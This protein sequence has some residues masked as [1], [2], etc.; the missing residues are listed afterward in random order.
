MSAHEVE[1]HEELLPEILS[2]EGDFRA[3]F[4]ASPL[5][6]CEECRRLF[7]DLDGFSMQLDDAGEAERR[8]VLEMG[9]APNQREAEAIERETGF[10]PE[11]VAA[12]LSAKFAASHETS[13]EMDSVSDPES[14]VE[15]ALGGAFSSPARYPIAMALAVVVLLGIG[16]GWALIA[17]EVEPAPWTP[18]GEE[19]RLVHPRDEVQSYAPFSWRAP[20]PDN[21]TFRV[22]VFDESTGRIGIEPLTSSGHLSRQTWT[23]SPGELEKLPGRIRWELRVYDASGALVRSLPAWAS[24]VSR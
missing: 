9:A 23:P 20:R 10:G 1:R 8:E 5:F 14:E 11:R 12:L 6:L 7:A 4:E 17:P 24:R 22:F 19:T 18:M 2:R 16:L 13:T 3:N 15:R 21:G